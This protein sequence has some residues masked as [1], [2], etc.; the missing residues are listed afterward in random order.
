MPSTLGKGTAVH[1]QR[2]C[3]GDAVQLEDLAD[4]EVNGFTGSGELGV[5]YKMYELG[6]SVSYGQ[7]DDVTLGGGRLLTNSKATC[8]QGRLGTGRG[9]RRRVVRT[10]RKHCTH[11]Q[12]EG[13]HLYDELP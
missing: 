10:L 13:V 5:G 3:P 2:Q 4:E 12:V 7:D 8:E 6:K 1:S 11:T 9:H